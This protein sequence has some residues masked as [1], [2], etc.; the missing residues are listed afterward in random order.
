MHGRDLLFAS[1]KTTL[2]TVEKL[3]LWMLLGGCLVSARSLCGGIRPEGDVLH[4]RLADQ[5]DLR[6]FLYGRHGWN[7][8]LC[9]NCMTEE[10]L[11]NVFDATV[12]PGFI[13]DKSRVATLKW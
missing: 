2:G 6:S 4:V 3:H 5:S 13:R 8:K 10:G 7:R 1:R 11:V 12:L 9:Q